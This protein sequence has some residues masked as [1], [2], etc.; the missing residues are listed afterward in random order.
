ML[1]AK[2][3]PMYKWKKEYMA[4]LPDDKEP[5]MLALE[6]G[7]GEIKVY[8][9]FVFPRGH[10]L[11]NIDYIE[12]VVKF[13]LW[14]FGGY[15]F[16]ICGD[17]R[18]TKKLRQIYSEEGLR[19]FDFNFMKKVFSRELEFVSVEELDFPIETEKPLAASKDMKGYKIGFDA[20][21]SDRKVTATIDSEVVFD[22]EDVWFP[23]LNSDPSYHKEGIRDSIN[24]AKQ[25]L[26]GRVDAIGVSTAGIVVANE[27]RVASLFIKVPDSIYEKEVV[28]IYKNLAAEYGCPVKVAN[29]GDVA[30]LA[31]AFSLGKGNVLG[32]AMGTS[33]AA[34]F[35]DENFQIK[36]Y[37]NELAFAP[38]DG[39]IGGARDDWSGDIGVGSQYHS[40][41]AVIRLAAE[42]GI[43]IDES[44]SLAE[45]LKVVQKLMEKGDARAKIIFEKL[46]EYFGYS[47]L[48]Y[49]EFYPFERVLLLG[50]VASGMGGDV[51]MNKAKQILV[52]EGSSIEIF[53]PDEK[54]RRLGQSYT[55][56]LL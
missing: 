41:D 35:V 29:D 12:R 34:G 15:R 20:G 49:R 39:F 11:D 43:E 17:E 31:G 40:Q 4:L 22:S 42:A 21:G 30:A 52:K 3:L 45:K 54:A 38:V 37:L 46:G 13:M 27:I 36:G 28:G 25:A 24:R 14:A 33:E 32:I 1:D 55:A 16:Y 8:K 47:I 56:T 19:S 6:R 26:G 2:Y 48:W 50:R 23:K 44:L 51:L 53:I 18:I 9:T 10:K 5:F 7:E